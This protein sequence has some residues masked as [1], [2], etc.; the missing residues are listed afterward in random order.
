MLGACGA[1]RPTFSLTVAFVPKT[2]LRFRAF[3]GPGGWRGETRF[4]IRFSKTKNLAEKKVCTP[5]PSLIKRFL[6]LEIAQDFAARR[7]AP[8][9]RIA[10]SVGD[11]P[12]AHWGER[13][14]CT[15]VELGERTLFVLVVVHVL[16][17]DF[18]PIL[19]DRGRRRGRE[20]QDF[21]ARRNV[22]NSRIALSVGDHPLAHWGERDG[23]MGWAWVTTCCGPDARAPVP[24][25]VL[26]MVCVR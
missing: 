17:I 24:R 16:V 1:T 6:C 11:H 26:T 13:D 18:R 12:L 25:L 19:R 15:A 5:P 7:N 23:V 9:S 20:A 2:F 14:G 22:P 8:N 21:A 3:T 10:L 4:A